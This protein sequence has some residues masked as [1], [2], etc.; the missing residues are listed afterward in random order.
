MA[1]EDLVSLLLSS[2]RVSTPLI[3]AAMGGL[4]S[5]RS[6]TV[7]IALEGFMLF[8]ALIGAVAAYFTGSAWL[9][10]MAAA[11]AGILL[12][13]VK[14]FFV[15]KLR[16]DQI[17]TGTAINILAVGMSPFIT[18]ILFNSTGQTPSLPLETRFYWAPIFIACSVALFLHYWFNKTLAGI[19]L[20]FSGEAPEALQAAG[21]SITKVRWLSLLSC[22]LLAGL[23]GGSLSLFLSSS[24]S[25]NM[26][27]GRGFMALAALIFGGWKPLPT[28]A[29]C[30]LFGFADA[31]QIRLQ[32][33]ETG[34]PVQFIQVLPYL[35]TIVALAGFFRQSRAPKM[36]GK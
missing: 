25:P 8:G 11:I 18:K 33:V 14:G 20:L 9:G 27:A 23:G 17:V 7:Q 35:M 6:G 29:V 2:F 5:E 34:V 16:A 19:W 26:T 12:A 3:F 1:Q 13:A 22:G 15:L 36:L 21:L 4:L 30:L 24:Y 32:G 10:F 31:L 28:F